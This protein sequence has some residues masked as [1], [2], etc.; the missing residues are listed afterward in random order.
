LLGQR[1]ELALLLPLAH[2]LA[3]QL[4]LVVSGDLAQ[5]HAH[6]RLASAARGLDLGVFRL[7]LERVWTHSELGE[8][9]VVLLAIAHDRASLLGRAGHH[10]DTPGEA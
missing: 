1:L 10:G 2:K 3:A 5:D 7:G 6:H 9:R 4:A 8:Q